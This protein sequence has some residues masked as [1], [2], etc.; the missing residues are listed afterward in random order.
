MTFRQ[1]Q[2][3]R[4]D[5]IRVHVSF[6][7]HYGIYESDTAVY[8]FGLPDNTGV[9]PE[10]ICV[11]CTPLAVFCAGGFVQVAQLTRAERKQARSV[12]LVI[13]AARARLGETG[14]HILY[15]NCEHFAT[16]CLFGTPR[17]ALVEEARASI[18]KKLG[19]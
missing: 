12:D 15:N 17:S 14:Y 8:A 11:V 1:G 19:H 18:R 16:S 5:L 3:S 13:A 6:Y 9:P 2:P 4:G 10:E 7:D